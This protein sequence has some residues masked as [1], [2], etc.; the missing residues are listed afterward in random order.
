MGMVGKYPFTPIVQPTPLLVA[1]KGILALHTKRCYDLHI[2]RA[3]HY[4]ICGA[5]YSPRRKRGRMPFIPAFQTVKA[6]LRQLYFG[7]EVQNVLWFTSENPIIDVTLGGVAAALID[8]WTTEMAP[9]KNI[10]HSLY[11]VRVVGQDDASFPEHVSSTA[12][13]GTVTGDGLPGSVALVVTFHTLFRGKSFRGRAYMGGIP[14]AAIEDATHSNT[15]NGGYTGDLLAA[16]AALV[17]TYIVPVDA[18][19]IHVVASHFAA[20]V[21][22][23]TAVTSAVIQYTANSAFDSQRRRL[24]GR[25]I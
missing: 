9:L 20:K 6:I 25:G 8:W 4:C 7:Q 13:A 5:L 19:M 17:P 22:R 15:A 16:F 23:V 2:A 11:E 21:A 12:V 10:N 14:E 1:G 24:N 18:T 3:I